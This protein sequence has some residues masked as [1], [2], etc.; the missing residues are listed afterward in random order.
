MHTPVEEALDA[1]RERLMHAL[2]ATQND[3]ECVR[4]RGATVNERAHQLRRCRDMEN[5][6]APQHYSKGLFKVNLRF[7]MPCRARRLSSQ[8]GDGLG[9]TKARQNS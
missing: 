3:H 1:G 8:A 2:S 6:R 5:K 4:R 9:I 7:V